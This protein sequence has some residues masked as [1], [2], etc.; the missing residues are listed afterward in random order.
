MKTGNML[1][2]HFCKQIMHQVSFPLFKCE[3][4]LDASMMQPRI[5]SHWAIFSSSQPD[6]S[7]KRGLSVLGIGMEQSVSGSQ[8]KNW[9]FM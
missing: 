1:I 3:T 7:G 5:V 4:Q 8:W 2:E 9:H 6:L